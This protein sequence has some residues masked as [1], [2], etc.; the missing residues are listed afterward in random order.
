MLS[1]T[2]IKAAS[3][4]FA[5]GVGILTNMLFILFLPDDELYV[6][7][8]IMALSGLTSSAAVSNNT[9]KIYGK[10]STGEDIQKIS[11]TALCLFGFEQLLAILFILVLL[12]FGQTWAVGLTTIEL[13]L[14]VL[15]S[16]AGALVAFV[17]AKDKYF[18]LFNIIRSVSSLFRLVVVFLLITINAEEWI[19]LAIIVSLTFPMAAALLFTIKV[20]LPL[21]LDENRPLSKPYILLHEYAWGIPV[22]LSRSFINQGLILA[23]V[24]LL[25]P[26]ELRMFRFL[27]LPKDIIGRAF[28]AFLPLVFDRMMKYSIRLVPSIGV[29]AFAVAI[30]IIWYAIGNSLFSFG[31]SAATSFVIF[32]VLNFTVYSVLPIAWRNI[33]REKARDVAIVVLVSTGMTALVFWATAPDSINLILIVM[34]VFSFC[35]IA[36][37]LIVSR[38]QFGQ[39]DILK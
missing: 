5:Q 15:V 2:R 34:S 25:N 1:A 16:C 37:M 6:V 33:H 32:L 27:L 11:R 13:A 9:A 8:G 19:P 14:L 39:P 31:W 35:Y 29:A 23:A 30:A 22:A 28:N 3:I 24:E 26:D 18:V 38:K 20:S 36:G 4:L 21:Y 17:R 7:I 10:I 12:T